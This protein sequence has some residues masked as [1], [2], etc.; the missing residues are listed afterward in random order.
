MLNK[1]ARQLI[2]YKDMVKELAAEIES[3]DLDELETK[4]L[5]EILG[6]KAIKW[7]FKDLYRLLRDIKRHKR[8]EAHRILTAE[9]IFNSLPWAAQQAAQ[10]AVIV[11]IKKAEAQLLFKMD[12]TTDMAAEFL[13]NMFYCMKIN[14]KETAKKM[15]EEK[16]AYSYN[17]IKENKI[18]LDFIEEMRRRQ[19]NGEGEV[20][21]IRIKNECIFKL[22]MKVN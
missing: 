16:K 12:E 11:L 14:I 1:R 20:A 22:G 2:G 21:R 4:N 6:E 13:W 3:E 15:A 17:E 8:A 7:E 19:W 10:E 9:A 18:L 5:K